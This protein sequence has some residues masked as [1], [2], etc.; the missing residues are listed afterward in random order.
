MISSFLTL[1]LSSLIKAYDLSVIALIKPILR[2]LFVVP[3]S[4]I[5]FKSLGVSS[6]LKSSS[7][8]LSISSSLIDVF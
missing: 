4:F 1:S 5:E 8:L 3:V 6:K 2:F 7:P